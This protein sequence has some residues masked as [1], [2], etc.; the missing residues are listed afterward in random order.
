MTAEENVYEEIPANPTH[1]NRDVIP[2]Y[3]R[4]SETNHY[5]NEAGFVN[6]YEALED[7]S[8]AGEKQYTKLATPK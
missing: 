8:N 7:N 3:L 6:E 5:E 4:I 2:E 1:S